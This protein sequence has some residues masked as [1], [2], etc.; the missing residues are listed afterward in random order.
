MP[1]HVLLL[2]L[3]LGMVF[4]F[5]ACGHIPGNTLSPVPSQTQPPE[6][7]SHAPL[8]YLYFSE[9]NSYFKRVQAYEFREENGR[10]TAYFHMANEEAPY[11]VE[12]DQG[13]ADE[14]RNILSSYGMREWNGFGGSASGLLDG[15]HFFVEFSFLNEPLIQA[16]GYGVFPNHYGEASAAMDAHFLQ[17]LPEDMR[18]W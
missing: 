1:K 15:T 12:V 6:P 2:C 8:T 9:S 17:L 7:L 13:W 4:I 16:S 10:N 5:C 3:L 18:D 11:P 14:L